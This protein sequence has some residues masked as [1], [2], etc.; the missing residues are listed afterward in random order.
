MFFGEENKIDRLSDPVD[1]IF[2]VD[3]YRQLVT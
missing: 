3:W 2:W 1:L